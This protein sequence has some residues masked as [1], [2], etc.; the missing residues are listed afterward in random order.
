MNTYMRVQVCD[1][2]DPKHMNRCLHQIEIVAIL[3]TLQL[4]HSTL[5]GPFISLIPES[6]ISQWFS[7]YNFH[8]FCLQLLILLKGKMKIPR[9]DRAVLRQTIIPFLTKH[10]L[11]QVFCS[12]P[13][14]FHITIGN[15]LFFTQDPFYDH[16][17]D[18][19]TAVWGQVRKVG[20]TVQRW[21][22]LV[23]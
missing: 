16:R 13:V 3:K 19:K 7:G 8:S 20:C 14:S 10:V 17:A 1:Y 6:L 4:C 22:R 9:P 21:E 11:A 18:L 12:S 2:F 15:T 23:P 5:I